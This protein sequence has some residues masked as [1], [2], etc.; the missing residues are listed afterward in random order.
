MLKCCIHTH[1]WLLKKKKNCKKKIFFMSLQLY[2]N[3]MEV[4]N[5]NQLINIWLTVMLYDF[6]KRSIHIGFQLKINVQC[7][8]TKCQAS[9]TKRNPFIHSE[10]NILSL[11][12]LKKCSLIHFRDSSLNFPFFYFY[13]YFLYKVKREY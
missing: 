9:C 10:L 2:K 5:Q 8:S 13:N 7:T 1:K 3:K 12:K 4:E 6:K 11:T